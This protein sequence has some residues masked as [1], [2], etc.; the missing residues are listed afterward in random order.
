MNIKAQ[1]ATLAPCDSMAQF[2]IRQLLAGI[3]VK[4]QVGEEIYEGR[5]YQLD[6]GEGANFMFARVHVPAFDETEGADGFASFKVAI[7]LNGVVTVLPEGNEGRT[8]T[9]H[10]VVFE[11]KCSELAGEKCLFADSGEAKRYRDMW[12]ADNGTCETRGAIVVPIPVY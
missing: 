1:K 4:M 5:I 9:V 11:D 2:I 8:V 3:R 12:N 7:N 6:F 10:A